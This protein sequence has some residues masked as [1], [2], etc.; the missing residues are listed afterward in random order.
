MFELVYHVM[1]VSECGFNWLIKK[2]RFFNHIIFMT[3]SIYE[4]IFNFKMFLKTNEAV[5]KLHTLH[6]TYL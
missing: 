2:D 5:T 4:C 6:K 1:F 3:S